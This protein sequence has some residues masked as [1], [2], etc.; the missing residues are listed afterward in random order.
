M[1]ELNISKELVEKI[2]EYF[3]NLKGDSYLIKSNYVKYYLKH[4]EKG[5][6]FKIITET[7]TQLLISI[8][9]ET[10]T[11]KE[12]R[13]SFGSLDRVFMFIDTDIAKEISFSDSLAIKFLLIDTNC[14]CDEDENVKKAILSKV[15]ITYLEEYAHKIKDETVRLNVSD[16]LLKSHLTQNPLMIIKE[17]LPNFFSHHKFYST[18]QT[19]CEDEWCDELASLFLSCFL[20][21]TWTTINAL[22]LGDYIDFYAD[23]LTKTQLTKFEQKRDKPINRLVDRVYN[24]WLEHNGL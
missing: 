9:P 19:V 23:I 17:F 7:I 8:E 11:A 6:S 16:F 22:P 12:Y 24:I 10:I 5:L 2:D 4:G 15:D 1:D 13:G 14:L 21:H 18:I 3:L 20:N